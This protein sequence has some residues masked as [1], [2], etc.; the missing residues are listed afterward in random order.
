MRESYSFVYTPQRYFEE[1]QN[2]IEL[3]GYMIGMESPS[4]GGKF[5]VTTGNAILEK[6]SLCA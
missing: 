1:D 3:V 4:G 6:S 2:G 5:G